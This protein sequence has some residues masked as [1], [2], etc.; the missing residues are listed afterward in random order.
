LIRTADNL[1]LASR[2]PSSYSPDG[3][4]GKHVVDCE[5]EP[6]TVLSIVR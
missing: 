5:F 4:L 1:W 2:T 3:L 6:W